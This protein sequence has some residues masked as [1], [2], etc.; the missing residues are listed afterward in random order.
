MAFGWTSDE[1]RREKIPEARSRW[2]FDGVS[3][4]FRSGVTPPAT[5][6]EGKPACPPPPRR[7]VRT[8]DG[9]GDR[10]I[11]FDHETREYD[12]VTDAMTDV[13]K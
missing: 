1:T 7:P 13:M 9:R 5:H 11:A 2:C 8:D 4:T 6:P 12:M 3:M 10:V